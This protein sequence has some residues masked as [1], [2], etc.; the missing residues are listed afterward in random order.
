MEQEN[1][2]MQIRLAQKGGKGSEKHRKKKNP[3]EQHA[4]FHLPVVQL[5]LATHVIALVEQGVTSLNVSVN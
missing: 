5:R 4:T 2:D 3:V 1:A